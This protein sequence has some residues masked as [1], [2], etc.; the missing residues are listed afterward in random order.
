M[1]IL[2]I[3][4]GGRE[5]AI[6]WALSK[7]DAVSRV[8]LSTHNGGTAGKIV[9]AGMAGNDFASIDAFLNSHPVD[10][11][12]VG[13]EKPLSEGLVDQLKANGVRVFGPVKAAARLESSKAFAKAFMDKHGIATAR[14]QRFDTYEGATVGLE[15]FGCPVV[16]KADGLC[17]GKGVTICQNEREA[18]NALREIF[19]DKVF[20]DEG[21]SVVMEQFLTGFEAS[22]VCFVSGTK[23]YPCQTAMDYKKIYEGDQGPNTGGVGCISPN[24]YWT[25]ELDEKSNAILRKI[26]HGFESEGLGYSGILFIGYMVQDGEPYVLEFNTRFGDP[27]TE[28]LLPRLSSDLLTNILQSIDHQPVELAFDKNVCMA[29]VLVSEGY[30]KSYRTGYDIAGLE[31]IDADARVFHNGTKIQGGKI[32]SAGGR[33]LTVTACAATLEAA[34]ERVYANVGRIHFENKAYRA[35]IGSIRRS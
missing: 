9:N 14:Y 25:A 28:V 4:N 16:I 15:S 26:E 3:G 11:V 20:A 34:R 2:V 21:S 1:E 29:T 8:Y 10:L 13:P 31:D 32:I 7:N 18:I 30:P 35:D 19:I 17:A 6:A 24:P 27:E 5:H 12:I 23:V 33:V 22:L